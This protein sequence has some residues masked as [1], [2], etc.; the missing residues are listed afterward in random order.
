MTEEAT[1]SGRQCFV[2]TPIGERDSQVRRSSDGLLDAVIKPSLDQLGFDV[3]AAHE[4]STPGSI[5]RQIIERLLEADLV[6]ANVTGLNPNVMYELA[7]RHAL[8][9]PIVTL[10]EEQT[11]LPFDIADER[12]IEFRDDMMGVEELRPELIDMVRRAMEEEPDNPVYRVAEAKVMRDVSVEDQD[13]GSYIL[14]R[15]DRLEAKI[16]RFADRKRPPGPQPGQ[17][18]GHS[19]RLEGEAETVEEYARGISKVVGRFRLIADRDYEDGRR[20]VM[21][22]TPDLSMDEF[23]K[24]TELHMRAMHDNGM[25]KFDIQV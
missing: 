3:E 12:T 10:K 2:I 17:S 19:I 8:A 11:D 20:M 7:V 24:L 4:I 6:V 18:E 5:T 1:Y 15:L 9:E 13:V 25:E 23:E 14:E 21:G 16:G 22:L